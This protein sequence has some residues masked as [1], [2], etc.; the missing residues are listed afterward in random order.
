MKAWQFTGTGRPLQLADLEIPQ[1]G[2]GKVL[3]K[4][5]AA[6]LCQSDVRSM[7]DAHGAAILVKTPITLGH[8]IA[9]TVRAVGDGVT[10]WKTGD[11]VGVC[12]TASAGTPAPKAR[13]PTRS[14]RATAT[15]ADSPSTTSAPPTT[16]CASRTSSTSPTALWPPMPA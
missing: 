16:S 15:T 13:P 5:G 12:P 8:E 11:R 3:L 10:E 4:V 2:P 14:P 1:P 7:Y 6:G 9:G